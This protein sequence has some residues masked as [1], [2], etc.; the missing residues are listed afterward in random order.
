MPLFSG[1]NI[2]TK[3]VKYDPLQLHQN[4]KVLKSCKLSLYLVQ[5]PGF[6]GHVFHSQGFISLTCCSCYYRDSVHTHI[7]Q[8]FTS[9]VEICFCKSR[10]RCWTRTR[11]SENTV[12]KT[13]LISTNPP[14]VLSLIVLETSI[15]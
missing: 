11:S 3:S 10:N 9:N 13:C 6:K 2:S 7:S 15:L 12:F 1:I 14:N 8:L 4:P 5:R